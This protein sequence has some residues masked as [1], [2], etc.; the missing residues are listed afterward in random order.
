M[1]SDS[2]GTVEGG[3]DGGTAIGCTTAGQQA[4][5]ATALV[6]VRLQHQLDGR[7]DVL[8][9]GIKLHQ[10]LGTVSFT[11]AQFLLCGDLLLRS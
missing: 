1:V 6:C 2:A 7:A 4:A 10:S 11:V 9:E 5:V 3:G 8:H